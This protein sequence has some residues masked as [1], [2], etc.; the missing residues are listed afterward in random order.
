MVIGDARTADS[1]PGSARMPWF[2]VLMTMTAYLALRGYLYGDGDHDDF[3][4]YLLHL[5]DSRLLT[6]DWYVSGQA[7]GYGPRTGFVLLTWLPAKLIG[8]FATFAAY[9]VVCWFAMAAGI[10]ALSLRI[11]GDR[12]AA[13][14]TVVALLLVTPKFTLGS[15]D[16]I[17]QQLAP[18]MI[19]WCLAV[20]GVVMH[21]R[22]RPG[23]AALLFGLTTWVQALIGLQ[24]AIVFGLM[25]LWE[26]QPLRSMLTYAGMFLAVSAP[27][28]APLVLQHWDASTTDPSLFHILFEF[29][30][31][32]HYIPTRFI[33]ESSLAFFALLAIGL[34]CLPVMRKERRTVPARLLAI[35]GLV[36]LVAFVG[37]EA[38]RSEFIGKVQLF[39]ITVLAKVALVIIVCAA[40]SR[41]LP[42]A[43]RRLLDS[44]FDR[45]RY[46]LTA[47]VLLTAALVIASPDALGF[48]P[49]AVAADSPPRAQITEWARTQTDTTSVFAVPPS[50]DSFR[51]RSERAVVVSFKAVPFTSARILQWYRRL[52]AAAPVNARPRERARDLLPRLDDAFFA[53][54]VE[55]L[56][57]VCQEYGAEYAVRRGPV[58]PPAPALEVVFSAEDLFVYR[59]TRP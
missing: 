34:A 33:I 39:R 59:I 4:P 30:A 35:I 37:T 42:A 6:A 5:L 10:H 24:I 43:V 14:G 13:A 36:C 53:L 3:L 29:R 57:A 27:A 50:W 38:L 52:L 48:R 44:L 49:P 58:D 40:I 1:G 7:A 22:S 55:E 25:M 26:R 16:L 12:L 32:H 45:P 20:W 46:A 51:S 8:P 47:A 19:G 9:Y 23:R 31:P 28:L 21:V 11:T 15:N 18:S 41:F 56:L 17:H 2:L 54:P